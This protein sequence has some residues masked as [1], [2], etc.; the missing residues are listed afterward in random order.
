M[1]LRVIGAGVGR[2]GTSSLTA[3]LAQLLGGVC[4]HFEDVI[5]RPEHVELWSEAIDKGNLDDWDRLYEGY[6]AT[7]DW[8]GA[9]FWKEVS[10][11]YPD[12]LVLLSVRSTT[13]QWFESAQGTIGTLVGDPDP[14]RSSGGAWLDMAGDLLRTR[15]VAAPF[16]RAAAEAAYESHNAAVRAAIPAER[17]LEWSPGDGWAPICARLDVAVPDVPFPHL[18]T[19]DQFQETLRDNSVPPARLRDKLRRSSRGGRG[20]H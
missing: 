8:P 17:L 19:R 12:A 6:V 5:A 11:F 7:M 14:Y 10:A 13:Q 16:D 20:R 15:F 9:A 4:Y 18:N 1:V 3:A 2:T